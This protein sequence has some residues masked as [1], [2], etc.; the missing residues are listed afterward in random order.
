MNL[1]KLAESFNYLSGIKDI[2]VLGEEIKLTSSQDEE[3]LNIIKKYVKDPDEANNKIQ[4][5]IDGDVKKPDIQDGDFADEFEAWKKKHNIKEGTC[6]YSVDGKP[7]DTPAGPN[8]IKKSDLNESV[9]KVVR[10]VLKQVVKEGNYF[11]S[12][13]EEVNE[14]I[15][16][17]IQEFRENQDGANL[18]DIAE[19]YN[20]NE[21]ELENALAEEPNEGN[22]FAV[23]RLK[24]I[25]AGEDEFEVGG[26][27]HKVTDVSD[28]D[29]KAAEEL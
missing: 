13:E 8:L 12:L 28:D 16:K 2:S 1:K 18:K 29:K 27:K 21:I 11:N 4:D 22:A 6:G 10:K 7:A 17:A 24:A 14:D 26:K 25:K 5:Y 9:R 15:Q 23:A 20:L 19:K 3:L